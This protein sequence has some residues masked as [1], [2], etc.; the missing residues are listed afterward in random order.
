YIV[1]RA[2][3]GTHERFLAFLIE[4][5]GGAF[6]TWMA[7][8]QVRVVPVNDKVSSYVDELV[9]KLREQLIRVEVDDS[10]NSFNKKIR[11]AVTQKVP[12]I[13]I[14]GGKEAESGNITLRRYCV[15][16]QITLSK[17]AFIARTVSLVKR[18]TMDNFPDTE[19][20]TD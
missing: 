5:L 14:I 12:N 18:R 16:E 17:E 20:K 11:A 6:P 19:I 3:L 1:H 10:D 8:V 2:P 13:A 4:H 9:S 7:P 15:K